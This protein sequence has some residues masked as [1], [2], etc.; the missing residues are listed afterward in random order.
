LLGDYVLEPAMRVPNGISSLL[1]SLFPYGPGAGMGFLLF[2]S[3]FGGVL[4]GVMGYFNSYTR[5]AED[6]LPDHDF[7]LLKEESSDSRR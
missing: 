5:N 6:I 2:V 1:G 3:C 7:I 4:A